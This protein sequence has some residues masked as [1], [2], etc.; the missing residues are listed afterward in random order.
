VLDECLGRR[1]PEGDFEQN[2]G[3]SLTTKPPRFVHE[4]PDALVAWRR[5]PLP[6]SDLTDTTTDLC[7]RHVPASV[8]LDFV[9][10]R[11]AHAGRTSHKLTIAASH[12]RDSQKFVPTSPCDNLQLGGLLALVA[13]VGSCPRQKSHRLR[14]EAFAATGEAELIR[15]RG[16]DGDPICADAERARQTFSHLI[17]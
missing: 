8:L 5:Q 12:E 15:R 7:D 10:K 14:G 17:P 1:R 4:H 3:R 9:M 2:T 16:A 6:S 11:L 13:F